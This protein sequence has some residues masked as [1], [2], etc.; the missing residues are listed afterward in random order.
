MYWTALEAEPAEIAAP[1]KLML[2]AGQR[3]TET[4]GMQWTEIEGEWWTIPG[5]R[6]KNGRAHRV[7]LG[8]TARA[9]LAGVKRRTSPY[10]FPGPTGE[11]VY[12][13]EDR[14]HRIMVRAGIRNFFI[15]DSRRTAATPLGD[16]GVAPYVVA[17]VLNHI[18]GTVTA[19]YNRHD[20]TAEKKKRS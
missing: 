16:L 11:P 12:R 17:A 15:E 13:P 4:I 19:I 6:A 20:Y 2:L 9:V 1:F 18:D 8:P 14:W 10:V 7:Y 3:K 5:A